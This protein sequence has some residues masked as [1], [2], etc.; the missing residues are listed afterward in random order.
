MVRNLDP[1]SPLIWMNKM[2]LR[3]MLSHLP[4]FWTQATI[5]VIR[6]NPSSDLGS[7]CRV[8]WGVLY[9]NT[10]LFCYWGFS[11]HLFLPSVIPN[12]AYIFF[13]WFAVAAESGC[14]H[15]LLFWQKSEADSSWGQMN[16]IISLCGS[17]STSLSSFSE[18][19]LMIF[20]IFGFESER[21]FT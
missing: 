6:V 10:S 1:K 3:R 19:I 16:C 13:V 14:E 8:T 4:T 18:W 2:K 17:L 15:P 21:R 9:R 12:Q 20:L 7:L 5:S 11:L